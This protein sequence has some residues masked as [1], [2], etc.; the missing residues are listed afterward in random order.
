M[1][2][3]SLSSGAKFGFKSW[4]YYLLVDAW[5]KQVLDLGL[6]SSLICNIG[7]TMGQPSQMFDADHW[8]NI[9]KA[10][11]PSRL[12]QILLQACPGKQA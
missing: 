4:L 6:L 9:F 3:K 5:G 8:I 11:G 12:E 2:V 10:L 1:A 7:I